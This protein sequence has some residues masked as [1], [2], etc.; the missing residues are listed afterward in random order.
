MTKQ[1][2]QKV[3]VG[4]TLI[5][6]TDHVIIVTR[7]LPSQGVYNDVPYKAE[8]EEDGY[9]H[10]SNCEYLSFPISKKQELIDAINDYCNDK[11]LSFTRRVK[12][13]DLWTGRRMKPVYACAVSFGMYYIHFPSYCQGFDMGEDI[14]YSLCELDEDVLVKILNRLKQEYEL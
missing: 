7:K 12:V 10:E 13:G 4:D 11:K 3:N 1:E 9:F 8:Y 5:E 14:E 2:F 6:G